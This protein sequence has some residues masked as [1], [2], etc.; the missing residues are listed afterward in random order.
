[1]EYECRDTVHEGWRFVVRRCHT[2]AGAPV[3]VKSVRE[4]ASGK[5]AGAALRHEYGILCK[6]ASSP[7]RPRISNALALDEGIAGPALVLADAGRQNLHE[8]LRHRPLEVSQALPLLVELAQIVAALHDQHVLHREI[9]PQNV[10]MGEDGRPTLVDFDAATQILG[11]SPEAMTAAHPGELYYLA[12]E[13]TG[14]MDRG[15]DHRADLYSLGATFYKVLTGSPPFAVSD[16]VEVTHAHLARAPVEPTTIN[17][18]VPRLLSELVLKL[19]AKAPER[20]YQSAAALALDLEEALRQWRRAQSLP[21]FELGRGDTQRP[22]PLP[23]R[24]YGRQRELERLRDNVARAAADGGRSLIAVFG[25]AGAGKSALIFELGKLL[26]A[27]S[28]LASGK[29]A[30][31]GADVPYALWAQALR[32]ILRECL[33]ASEA[34]R[35][36]LRDSLDE[37]IGRNVQLLF[38][39]LPELEDLAGPQKPVASLGA[40]ES[41]K[42]F[43]RTL[44]SL[45][46]TLAESFRPLVLFLDDLQWADASSFD[47][48][49][50]LAT[51]RLDP[52]SP[53][54]LVLI[55]AYRGDDAAARERVDAILA[56]A[57]DAGTRVET[58][59]ITALDEAAITALL[60]DTLQTS[61]EAVA[62]LARSILRKTAGNALFVRRFLSRIHDQGALVF[63]VSRGA[64]TWDEGRVDGAEA[65]ENVSSL[66]LDTMKGLSGDIQDLLAMAACFKGPFDLDDL[67]AIAGQDR[68]PVARRLW[69]P[70]REGLLAGRG[71][72]SETASYR[73][74]HDQVHEAAYELIADERRRQEIHLVI[75]RHLREQ[76]ERGRRVSIFDVVDHGSRGAPLI[77]SDAERLE[78]AR[79]CAEA[80]NAARASNAYG[81]GLGY[82]TRGLD[83]LRTIGPLEDRR[84]LAFRL[85]RDAAECAFL[86]GDDDRASQLIA[87]GRSL[88]SSGFEV[89][90]LANLE[91]IAASTRGEMEAAIERGREGL[92]ALGLELPADRERAAEREL[93][94]VRT[95][96]ARGQES[97]LLGLPVME[98]RTRL[99][100]MELLANLISP[101]YVSD[102]QLLEFI[103]AR[104]VNTSLEHGNAVYSPL[105]YATLG[106]ALC[107]LKRDYET[108]HAL[109]RAG[110]EL[111]RSFDDPVQECRT[112]HV[113]GC[114]INHWRAPL[115]MSV[116][117]LRRAVSRGLEG[118]EL[119]FAV[120]AAGTVVVAR[121]HRG[122]PLADISAEIESF[123]GLAASVRA[124]AGQDYLLAYR[125]AIRS[126]KGSTRE[127]G[128][129]EDETFDESIYLASSGDNPLSLSLYYTLRLEVA[130]LA[131]RYDEAIAMAD[132]AARHLGLVGGIAPLA[133]HRFF[134][135]L[136]LAAREDAGRFCQAIEERLGELALWADRAPTNYRHKYL[137]VLAELARLAGD[138]SAAAARYDEAIDAADQVEATRDAAIANEAAARFWRGQGRRRIAK[139]YASA[140]L[141]GYAQ[142]GANA[143]VAALEQAFPEVAAGGPALWRAGA[144]AGAE[145]ATLDLMALHRAYETLSSEVVLDR[146]LDKLMTLSLEVAGATGGALLLDDGGTLVQRASAP[147]ERPPDVIRAIAHEVRERDE[148][149][150]FGEPWQGRELGVEQALREGGAHSVLALPIPRKTGP[151]GVLYLE[152]RLTTN[153][154]PAARVRVLTLLSSQIATS[155]ENSLLFEGLNVEIADRKRAEQSVR[156]LADASA[157]LVRSLDH[158]TIVSRIGELAVPFLADW[159]AVYPS[160]DEDPDVQGAVLHPAHLADRSMLDPPAHSLL[161]EAIAEVAASGEA[162]IWGVGDGRGSHLPPGTQAI[163][164]VPLAARDRGL[165]VL[166]CGGGR[167]YGEG[168]RILARELAHRAAFAMDNARLYAQAQRAVSVRDEFLSIA[169]HEL[170]TPLTSLTLVAQGLV[171]GAIEKGGTRDLGRVLQILDRQVA[172]LSKLVDDLL[173]VSRIHAGRLHLNVEDVDLADVVRDVADSFES[174][175]ARAGCTISVRTGEAVVG[176]WDR[177][178][179]EQVVTNLVANALKFGAGEPIE[180]ELSGGA[181]SATLEVTDHGVGILPER[182]DSIFDRFQ[183]A[184]PAAHYGGLGLGLYITKQIVTALG[185]SVAPRSEPGVY[186]T[187]T[188]ELPMRGPAASPSAPTR[189][190][191]ADR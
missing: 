139:L 153:A 74:A 180:I 162:S 84:E 15:V 119:Q 18:K 161:S 2:A 27:G 136:A 144:E 17:P 152:N 83:L 3:V 103:A 165:G 109:G 34:E 5:D 43:H 89:A 169:S 135:A 100:R 188:V 104:M 141:E 187:F 166:V 186:T 63:D 36:R 87:D 47:L 168:D 156:F 142:W 90:D 13:Q 95:S 46:R 178:R 158:T 112:L 41:E 20:R 140:A 110:A 85:S 117:I 57:P 191:H 143:K 160:N 52:E 111:S 79:E 75:G 53:V 69:A 97:G 32:P 149:I 25:P 105:A 16:P 58:L 62:P 24:L 31:A 48:L 94:A 147:A 22:L 134:H 137:L 106:M 189:H 92:A 35:R 159:C 51:E 72:A 185:G 172:Q 171:Q 14:R 78:L 101:A 130:F 50:L 64:W 126:L 26:P 118:G 67:A 177:A 148:P 154:F 175:A 155:L 182:M 132:R 21:P 176:R 66:M 108:A 81:S 120:Y 39:L 190:G 59:P 127:L 65:T 170:K 23:A 164:S 91:V 183:R 56:A 173:S 82:L 1:M 7:H 114:F 88:A 11:L 184:A 8:F 68:E 99:A 37:E 60:A 28:A 181:H 122:E 4:G 6:V 124:K 70:V 55:A 167:P 12:P 19:L 179:L 151:A 157:S 113:F 150:V 76:R 54:S 45:V 116:S 93:A 10:V 107:A 128:D 61:P 145:H 86:S 98:D 121:Y 123:F 133:D 38:D 129:F 77:D 80:G 138:V 40:V 9:S 44:V 163:L 174:Q 30:L 42:R 131:G 125:Q 29:A 102:P 146:L 33:D 115:S 71:D 49:H 73:F 96:L